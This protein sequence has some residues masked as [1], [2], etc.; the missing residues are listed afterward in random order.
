MKLNYA[1]LVL[2]GIPTA[3]SGQDEAV[4]ETRQNGLKLAYSVTTLDPF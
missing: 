4:R 2:L 1:V 3:L